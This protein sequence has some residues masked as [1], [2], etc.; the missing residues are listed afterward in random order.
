MTGKEKERVAVV[1]P[2]YKDTLSV[3]EQYALEQCSKV[4]CNYPVIAI[5]PESLDLSFLPVTMRSISFGDAY[6]KDV[7]GYNRLM[8]TAGFYRQFS[9]YEYILIYQLDAFVF[10]DELL[11]WCDKGYDYIGAPWEE[12]ALNGPLGKLRF[13]IRAWFYIRYNIKRHNGLPAVKKTMPGRV[14]NGG[15]SLR[16]T[17]AF[18]SCLEKYAHIA[19]MYRSSTDTAFNEDVFWSIEMNRKTKHIKTPGFREALKFSVETTP[20]LAFRLNNNELPFG[21][22]AWD[23]Y[24]DFW[25]PVFRS[26]GYDI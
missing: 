2:F 4:L 19:E 1:I 3:Y 22:H 11:S 15:F 24:A 12:K 17:A 7:T 26:F 10:K 20:E 18:I 23:E 16:R 8:L 14:G 13:R 5:K 9:D 25:R 21:C 6:F